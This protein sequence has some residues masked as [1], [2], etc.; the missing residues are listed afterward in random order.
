MV[1]HIT[2]LQPGKFIHIVGDF[3]AY[4]NHRDAIE[5]QVSRTPY[6]FP[7]L[8]VDTEGV[9]HIEDFA[10]RHFRLDEYECHERISAPMTV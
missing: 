8:H 2:H 5:T 10:L 7:R 4:D 6:P 9:N 1:A 3:H